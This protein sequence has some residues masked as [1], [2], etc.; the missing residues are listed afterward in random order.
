M[1]YCWDWLCFYCIFHFNQSYTP[2]QNSKVHENVFLRQSYFLLSLSAMF[3]LS[4]S[5]LSINTILCVED[6]WFFLLPHIWLH[7]LIYYVCL[8]IH[9]CMGAHEHANTH[10]HEGQ[11]W[12]I[13]LKC[14]PEY[15]LRQ[16]HWDL[17][18]ANVTRL[19]GEDHGPSLQSPSSGITSMY[20]RARLLMTF[21]YPKEL[22]VVLLL[23]MTFPQIESEAR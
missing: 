6:P 23:W 7:L 16:S 9:M 12:V 22:R 3:F 13:F 1:T 18:L 15:F 14:C 17:G 10:A 5:S 20:Y 11:P 21:N 8:H 2:I 19:A 4:T